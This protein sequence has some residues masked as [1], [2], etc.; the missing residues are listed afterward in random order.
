MPFSLYRH[1][2]VKGAVMRRKRAHR[3]IRGLLFKKGT[4]VSRNVFFRTMPLFLLLILA[5]TRSGYGW[6]FTWNPFSSPRKNKVEKEEMADKNAGVACIFFRDSYAAGGY[7]YAYPAGSTVSIDRQIFH[8]GKRSLRFTLAHDDYSGGAVC[9]DRKLCDLSGYLK[10][11]ALQFWIK[12][13][14]GGEKALAA[15]VDEEKSDGKKTVVRLAVDWFGQITGEW[16]LVSIPL[17]HFGEKGVYWDEK[18]RREVDN[19]FDWDRVA[20]FRIEVK[21]DENSA[22]T[23]WVDD[24]VVVKSLR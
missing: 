21:K 19:D 24:I 13:S 20:E 16:T 2:A 8:G 23:I 10:H 1:F 14:Q 9:L 11:G 6:K 7:Q 4:L 18:E 3:H 17:E 22:F 5:G 15:L 12:G